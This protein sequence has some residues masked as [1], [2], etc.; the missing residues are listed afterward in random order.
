MTDVSVGY[1]GMDSAASRLQQGQE[2]MTEQLQ[3]L[4]SMIDNLVGGE[5][6]TQLASPK[7]QESYEQWNQG[8]TQML[9]G[10]DGMSSFLN[11]AVSG[12]QELDSNLSSGASGLA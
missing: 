5:F 3:S 9:E 2:E 10:L 4:Q 8:A 6:R 1:E 12:F 7:F 11:Q